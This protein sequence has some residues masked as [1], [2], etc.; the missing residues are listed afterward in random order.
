ML[1]LLSKTIVVLSLLNPVV[2][3][4]QDCKK[5]IKIGIIDTG[6]DLSDIRFS[7]HLCKFGHENFVQNE[8]LED[9]NGH[10]THIAGL[11]Q[12]YAGEGSYCFVILKYYGDE[13]SGSQNMKNSLKALKK[14]KA[15]K[16][17]FLNY[18]GGGPEFSEDEYFLIKNNPKTTFIVA[19]GND[20][21]S[22]DTFKYQYFPASYKLPNKIVVG[23]L[24]K[25]NNRLISSNWGS[26]VKF[27]EIGENVQSTYPYALASAGRAYI[28]GTSQATAIR[29]GKEVAKRLGMCHSR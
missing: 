16:L 15:L 14:I 20:R 25:S 11:I 3:W 9:I 7:K 18:S 21:A 27:W 8:T 19:A 17:D 4:A 13:N 10:G 29:T 5:P 1:H 22:L 23:A 12:Q 26:I 28:S 6:L 2:G 24:D